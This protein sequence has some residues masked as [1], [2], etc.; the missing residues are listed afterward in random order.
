MAI[1]KKVHDFMERASWIRKMFEEGIRLKK[2][3][4][5]ENVFDLSLGNPVAEPPAELVDAMG[6]AARDQS[7]G[8]HRYMPNA[9]LESTRQAVAEGLSDECKV[10]LIAGDIVMVCGA[11]GGLN[12]TLKTLLDPGDEVIVFAPYF[13]EYLFYADN[14]G[15]RAV[16]VNTRDDFSI[17]L[18]SFRA[19]VTSK[20]KA[21]IINSPNNPT[22][23]VYSRADLQGLADVLREKSQEIGRAI[24]LISD[25]PYKKIVF[26]GVETPNV[27]DI[28]ENSIYITSHSKDL[29]VPGERIGY[30]AVHP[31]AE[32]AAGVMAGLIFCNRVLG[33]V[34]AP[35]LFQRVVEKVQHVTVDVEPYRRRRDMLYKELTG[36]GYDVVKPQGAFYFFPKSPIEDEVEFARILATKK[37]LVVPGRGFGTPGYFRISTCFPDRVIEGALPGLA[38]AYREATG[39]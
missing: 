12:I 34:N 33:F 1:S 5:E 22:G 36:I 35:A 9:G 24:Y 15:G 8:R 7:P 20:T 39:K 3:F 26:D 37:V 17:D 29:A 18:E 14:H 16:A 11:A 27:L 2:E 6:A 4:G 38:E 32:D 21:V 28:Y 23:V 10:S 19:A 13:V 25:D 31:Q 30:V